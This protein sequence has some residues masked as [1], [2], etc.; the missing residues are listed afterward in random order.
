[1]ALNDNNNVEDMEESDDGYDSDL[2]LNAE[3]AAEF[4]CA[5]CTCICKDPVETTPCGHLYCRGCLQSHLNINSVSDLNKKQEEELSCCPSCR[6]A[7]EETSSSK[8]VERQVSKLRVKCANHA[9]GCEWKGE[10]KYFKAH[11]RE[12][13]DFVKL[14]CVYCQQAEYLRCKQQQHFSQCEQYP[15]ECKLCHSKIKRKSLDMHNQKLC[16]NL[17]IECP[18][19]CG[20]KIKQSALQSHLQSECSLRRVPCLY[21]A[22][23]CRLRPKHADFKLHLS[24]HQ[25]VHLELKVLYLQRLAQ[26]TELICVS[27]TTGLFPEISGTYQR[28][29][30]PYLARPVWR[31]RNHEKFVV[32]F[33]QALNS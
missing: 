7:I 30:T 27:N 9:E 3:K 18:S 21:E 17:L 1:M 19:H 22:Y 15:I 8:F 11:L 31:N 6:A 20:S 14:Q 4:K 5:I 26:S 28:E 25:V 24:Q 13:C 23:G 32:R 33:D 16:P 10:L 29:Q 12:K 2:F